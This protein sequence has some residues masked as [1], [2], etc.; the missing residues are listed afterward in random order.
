MKEI[1]II[2]C[3]WK[4]IHPFVEAYIRENNITVESFWEDHVIYAGRK[5]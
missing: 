5:A 1:D 4:E 2:P 3:E